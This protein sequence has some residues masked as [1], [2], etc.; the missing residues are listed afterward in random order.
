[1]F[2]FIA[3]HFLAKMFV[4]GFTMFR[5]YHIDKIHYD[6]PSHIAKSKLSR[7]FCCSHFIN[8]QRMLFVGALL[9]TRWRSLKPMLAVGLGL[10]LFCLLLTF[11][12]SAWLGAA[13][14]AVV[15]AG[16]YFVRRYDMRQLL[17]AHQ[18][19]VSALLV[20]LIF[21]TTVAIAAKDSY[22]MQNVIFHA[23]STTT[24]EDPNELRLR[25]WQESLDAA[26]EQPF[27]YGPGTAG[28]APVIVLAIGGAAVFNG[29]HPNLADHVLEL[30]LG[31]P[32]EPLGPEHG[33]VTRETLALRQERERFAR[34]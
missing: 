1:M 23:D 25:F 10:T 6:N 24:L 17:A 13:V 14:A 2:R 11:S 5:I 34:R 31:R 18:Q 21:L 19:V 9:A 7:N 32:L 27:G 22:F 33:Q 12:R 8:V 26:A 20:G 28:L 4:Q 15:F 16:L 3:F 29:G 30:A